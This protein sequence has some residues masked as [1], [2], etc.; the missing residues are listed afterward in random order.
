MTYKKK[1]TL[2]KWESSYHKNRLREVVLARLRVNCVKD[3]HLIPRIEGNYLID[4]GCGIR[5][6]LQHVFFD[7][8]YF[9][10]QRQPIIDILRR[11]K[12]NM[13]MKS[14]LEDNIDYGDIIMNFLRETDFIDHV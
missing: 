10:N 9:I 2:G 14:I 7:C 6:T 8:H 12:K 11:D 5:M 4:C 1:D 13:D 3:I